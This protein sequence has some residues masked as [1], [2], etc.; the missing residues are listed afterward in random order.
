MEPPKPGMKRITVRSK[1]PNPLFEKWLDDWRQEASD[2]GSDMQ[3]C[4]AKALRSLRKYPL[5]L[6][7][8]KECMILECF[9]NRL[10]QLLDRKLTEYKKTNPE[11]DT[12]LSG[13]VVAE[14]TASELPRKRKSPKKKKTN[15]AQ[16]TEVDS[17]PPDKVSKR[18]GREY[19]PAWRSGPFALLLALLN[20]EEKSD[21]E[22]FMLKA[23]LQREAQPL[24]DKSFTRPDPG[25]HYTA[26]SS[27]S[28]LLK[29]GL[30][31]KCSNPA[32]FS[33]SSEG[34]DLARCLRKHQDGDTYLQ[35]QQTSA[36][37]SPQREAY[38]KPD[39]PLVK[40][41]SKICT[42]RIKTA[43]RDWEMTSSSSQVDHLHNLAEKKNNERERPPNGI[44][45]DTD[46]SAVLE[47]GSF[48]VLLLVDTCET[49]GATKKNHNQTVSELTQ[50]KVPFEVR[51][52]EVGDFVWIARSRVCK[53][54]E[55]VLP[56]IVE[57]KRMDD[58][59]SSIKDRRFHEQKFRL[60]QSGIQNL[61]Y[62]VESHGSDQH[63]GLPLS[64]LQQAA[65]N[66]QLVDGFI[67]KHTIDH[68]HSMAYLASLTRILGRDFQSKT[69]LG[70]LRKDLV[71]YTIAD[72]FVTLINFKEFKQSTKKNKNFTVKE[73]FIRQLVQLKGL[74][75]EKAIAITG[76]YPTPQA[77]I[78]AYR[79]GGDEN[80][81]ADIPCLGT[82]S[83]RNVGSGCSK[84]VHFLYS[85]EM[86]R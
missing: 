19:V 54:T 31:S 70:C 23:E 33:L 67:V 44:S 3:Y 68:R 32:K 40:K 38:S 48:D 50:M 10:C 58:L 71:E 9:G 81:L 62:L 78:Q 25:S 74:S 60:K 36:C 37:G 43:A 80:M 8:G 2:K 11:V 27:M 59:G 7:T 20:R 15:D 64:T 53:D 76:R 42:A 22:G 12:E 86:L 73:M 18:A 84:A 1:C 52:L 51:K 35:A 13:N 77:L 57:R 30:V 49:G 21:Y 14:L 82:A 65:V 69:L 56:Y 26:W 85:S 83:C 29:K 79:L 4:F 66:T 16:D 6:K 55:L 47:S 72:D 75:V 46:P 61:I 63:V 34:R 41:T 5:P 24:C 28:Q 17:E 39:S 45:C